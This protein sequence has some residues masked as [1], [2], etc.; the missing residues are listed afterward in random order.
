MFRPSPLILA[1]SLFAAAPAMAADQQGD[2]A[3]HG[4]GSQTC[5]QYLD[6]IQAGAGSQE[7]LIYVSWAQGYI[8][9]INRNLQG[10][11]DSLPTSSANNIATLL[12]RICRDRPDSAYE[13]A[14]VGLINAFAPMRLGVN[15]PVIEL[16]RGDQT[17]RVRKAALAQV[18]RYLKETGRYG[19]NVD[20]V[21]GERTAEAITAFQAEAEIPQTGLPDLNT[22]AAILARIVQAQQQGSN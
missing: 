14:V 16:N 9:S 1:A 15:S 21:F 4:A 18:Q 3:V 7:V 8:S 6:A 22:F 5:Q 19:G 12:S 11:F 10:V 13:S 17:L 2:F 20:G